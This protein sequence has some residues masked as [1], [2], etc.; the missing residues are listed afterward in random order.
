VDEG[1]KRN[2]L[3][4]NA[5]PTKDFFIHMLGRDIELIPAIIDLVDNCLDGARRE[6]PGADFSGLWVRVEANNT[7]FRIADNCGGISLEV[8]R[9]YAFRFGRPEGMEATRH[10]VGQ[11]GVGMK[12]ALFKLGGQFSVAS[13]TTEEQ[14]T[15]EVNVSE[16][17]AEPEWE[18]SI[19]NYS[20]TDG[21]RGDPGTTIV[22][23][24]LHEQVQER[25]SRESFIAQLSA[26][27]SRK[28]QP[29][30]ADG[31]AI[32]LNGVPLD[33]DVTTLL[34]SDD[35]GPVARDLSFYSDTD[36]PVTV[37]LFAGLSLC[38]S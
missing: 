37:K 7:H 22:V 9:K 38:Y 23:T 1:N 11:F 6:R 21:A 2:V 25:F 29:S 26:E 3:V 8:A 15:V 14:F 33:V 28:H 10:S 4:A 27:I 24:D 19:T 20:T 35:F 18:F 30:M 16:W 32:S 12:R 5:A 31:L 34:Q 13:L 36:S 17:R